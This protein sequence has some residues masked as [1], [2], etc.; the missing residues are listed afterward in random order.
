[1]N[2]DKIPTKTVYFLQNWMYDLF[3]CF[4]FP[5][6]YAK[7]TFCPCIAHADNYYRFH[8][9]HYN[10]Q[11]LLYILC[12]CIVQGILRSRIQ[13]KFG[14]VSYPLDNFSL[15]CLLAPCVLAQE[16]LEMDYHNIA[17]PI[18]HNMI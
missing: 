12:G 17:H 15:S 4:R 5:T 1:M 16:K 10:R 18:Y 14:L 8:G 2:Y 11:V 9:K 7:T 13:D 6:L 3:S